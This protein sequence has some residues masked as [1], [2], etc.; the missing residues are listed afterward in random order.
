[1]GPTGLRLLTLCLL[2]TIGHQPSAF[3]TP[4]SDDMVLVPAGEFTMGA[5]AESGGL[6]DERPLRLIYLSAFW[7]DRYEVTNAVYQQFVQATGYQAPANPAPALTLWAHNAPLPGIEQHPVVNV[8]W[9]D[10]VAFCRWAN[11]RLPT[12]AEWEKAARGTDG[13]IYPWGSEWDFEKGNSASYWAK[14]T[15][16][17]ADSTEWEAFWIK[18][19]GAAISKEKGLRGE[20][21]T[22]P[23]GSF[24]AG[25]SPYGALDMAGNAAE[26]VQDWYNP[27]D[28]RTAP[29]T[30]PLGPERGAIKA[31][32]GGSWLKPAISLRT[33][34]RDWGTMDSR[35]SGT[36]FRCAKDAY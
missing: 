6:P 25:V 16:H 12:E 9:L 27:N 8:S 7:I 26:W 32:R 18:G 35:P 30:N 15:V 22:L 21:L 33:T 13:R 29:L 14:R 4:L 24:P 23:V 10:A 36:G 31:M 5:S 34:D 19:E 3:G 1:M 17:F 2:L 11:K 20:I 28:Y